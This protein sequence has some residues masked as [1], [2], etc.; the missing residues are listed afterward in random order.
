MNGYLTKMDTM[1]IYSK[2]TVFAPVCISAFFFAILIYGCLFSK[3]DSPYVA[4]V[5]RKK[6]IQSEFIEMIPE[7]YR[8]NIT[9]SLRYNYIN[10]WVDEELLYEEALKRKLHE[11]P[12]VKRIL[13]NIQ[14][15]F[16]ISELK[17]HIT[18]KEP[19]I[20]DEKIKKYYNDHKEN[21]IRNF[22]E[23]KARIILLS[24]DNGDESMKNAEKLR[25]RIRREDINFSDAAKQFSRHPSS[26]RGGNV[27]IISRDKIDEEIWDV[28]EETD[29]GRVSIPILTSEGY[30]LVIVDKRY[31][32]G[33]IKELDQVKDEIRNILIIEQQNRA[34]AQFIKRLRINAEIE[35]P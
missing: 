22:E 9:P 13:D 4:K 34:L 33:T 2:K 21:F 19:D 18:T 5:N 10:R 7:P 26:S 28:I 15:D 31:E 1:M 12:A 29:T 23:V 30:Y 35:I 3:D 27:G 24:N 32:P 17:S 6:L 20:S 8:S 11:E 16:L 25:D 14:R